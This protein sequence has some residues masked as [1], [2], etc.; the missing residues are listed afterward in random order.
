[1]NK[2]MQMIS[3]DNIK[4]LIYTIRDQQV[5]LDSDLAVIYEVETKQINRAVKRNE[6]RFPKEFIFQM[7]KE[8]WNNLKYQT[9]TS[10]Q[11]GGRRTQPYVFTEQGVAMLSAVLS[12]ERAVK[13]SVQIINAF[14]EMRRFISH[15]TPVLQ[16][17]DRLEMKQLRDKSEIDN[18]IETLLKSLGHGEKTPKQGI[19]FNGEIYDAHVLISKIIRSARKSI[20]LIDNYIDENVLVLLSKKPV[21][22]TLKIITKKISESLEMDISKFREQYGE[23]IIEESK[24]FHDR[25]LVI[26]G[27]DIYHSGASFK[28]LGKKIS[29]FSKFELDTVKLLEIL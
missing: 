4:N 19:I 24:S 13:V 21:H 23:I 9:G 5:M 22:V 14:V 11:H 12:S 7:T 15:F 29:A 25:F 20:V 3:S 27:K 6:H 28:D 16:R 10:S 8:E 1:M 17:L 2:E 18:K 26:D